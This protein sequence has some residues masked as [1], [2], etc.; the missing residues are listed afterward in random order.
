MVEKQKLIQKTILA[1]NIAGDTAVGHTVTFAQAYESLAGIEMDETTKITRTIAL[2]LE[3]IAMHTADLG[4]ISIGLAF[5]MGASVYGR[6]RTPIINFFLQ[7]CGNRFAK[8]LIRV[9]TNAYPLTDELKNKLIQI[10]DNYEKDFSEISKEFFSASSVLAR[11]EKT[12]VVTHEQVSSFGAV[13]ITARMS[14]LDRDIRSSHPANYYPK[15]DH[16][17]ILKNHGDIYSRLQLR[18]EEIIQSI[19]Y[20][21]QMLSLLPSVPN[22]QP[23]SASGSTIRNPQSAIVLNCPAPNHLTL[24]LVEG[25]R[26]EICHTIITD[27]N[28]KIKFYKIKDPSFHN[29]LALALSVREHEISDFPINN[30][31]FNLSYCGNDL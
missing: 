19:S 3:R 13:G 25:W 12:G 7:W 4:N 29:W 14:H 31:S 26:G 23:T 9:G 16:H 18:K 17:P 28:G 15:L 5:L 21:R 2:E 8:G 20:L 22:P 24:S 11:I 1:E 30:K 6:L 10:L 27:E